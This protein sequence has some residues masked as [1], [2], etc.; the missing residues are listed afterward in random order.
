MG[1]GVG[2]GKAYVYYDFMLIDTNVGERLK[3][4]NGFKKRWTQPEIKAIFRGMNTTENGKA[5]GLEDI[6]LK[7]FRKYG[8]EYEIKFILPKW[9]WSVSIPYLF[10]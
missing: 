2:S 7:K 4:L 6:L 8:E 10:I 5:V 3:F 1:G 9:C